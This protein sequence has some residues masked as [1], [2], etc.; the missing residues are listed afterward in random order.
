VEVPTVKVL[1]VATAYPRHADDIITPWLVELIQRLRKRGIQVS[2]F[3]SSYRGLGDQTLDGVAIYRFRYFVKQYERLT[4]EETAVDRVKRGSLYVVLTLFYLLF[5]T[6]AIVRLVRKQQFDIIHVHWPFPHMLFGVFAKTAGHVRLVATFYGVEIRWLKQKFP[7]LVRPFASFLKKVDTITAI[8]THTARELAAITPRK[9][10]IVPFSAA[11]GPRTGTT[12][13]AK[14]I[15]FVGRL[16]ERKG[17]RYLIEAFAQ[18]KN[19][20]PHQLVIIGDGP[21]RKS[22]VQRAHDLN[23]HDRVTFTGR[24]SDQE[25]QK[26]YNQ[27]SFIV[28]PAVYDAKGDIEGLGVVLLEAMSYAKPAIASN[29][30]GIT[31]IVVNGENGFLVPPGDV[32]ALAQA[33]ERLSRNDTER[34][35]MGQ[36]AKQVVDEKFSWDRIT[37]ELISVYERT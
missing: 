26:H 32:R 12:S 35:Q 30:G 10:E 25:L 7:F 8:S 13:D 9:I 21:E 27:C 24:I 4:H 20:I 36:C 2:V 23:L 17:V 18:V 3:T 28:L 37:D 1:M 16:V 34:E 33:M 14:E 6:L 11:L 19:N 5:G 31:D 15:I 29:A 22:L